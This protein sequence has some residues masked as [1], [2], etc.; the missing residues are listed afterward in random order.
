MRILLLAVDA[1]DLTHDEEV[2]LGGVAS[3]FVVQGLEEFVK[4]RD[5]RYT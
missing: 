2:L 3:G 1:E 5:A 4:F